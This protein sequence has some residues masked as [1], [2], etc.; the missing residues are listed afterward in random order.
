M[1]FNNLLNYFTMLHKLVWYDYLWHLIYSGLYFLITDFIWT[2]DL[3]TDARLQIK[4]NKNSTCILEC[5]KKNY[6]YNR[7]EKYDFELFL[8]VLKLKMF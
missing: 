5:G 2:I 7:L 6:L 8:W 3:I 1:N 4:I